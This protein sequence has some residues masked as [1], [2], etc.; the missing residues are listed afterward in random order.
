MIDV[1]IGQYL[2]GDSL[3]HKADPRVKIIVTLLFMVSVF[4]CR[5]PV[6]L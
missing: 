5:F 3:I 2:P 1:T 6:L 4:L